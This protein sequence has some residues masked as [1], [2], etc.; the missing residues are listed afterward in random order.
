VAGLWTAM[1]T[2]AGTTL[3]LQP[4][5]AVPTADRRAL[6]TE[7]E[8]LARFIDPDGASVDVAWG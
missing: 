4:F 7:G 5:G 8:R 3:R 1:T 6:E 2:K